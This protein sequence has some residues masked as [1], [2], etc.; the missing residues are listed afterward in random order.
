MITRTQQRALGLS[1][2]TLRVLTRDESLWLLTKRQRREI[3]GELTNLMFRAS[4]LRIALKA[5]DAA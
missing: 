5:L 2:E 4:V 1:Q 3:E